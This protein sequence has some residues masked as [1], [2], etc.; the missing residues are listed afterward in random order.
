MSV[1]RAWIEEHLGAGTRDRPFSFTYGGS[2]S[3]DLLPGWRTTVDRE[4]LDAGRVRHLL[5][6]RDLRTGLV[7]RCEAIEY[8]AYD[9][10]E[11]ITYCRNEGDVDTPIIE[12]FKPI[13]MVVDSGGSDGFRVY[14]SRGSDSKVNDYE[15]LCEPVS[16]GSPLGLHSHGVKTC[17]EGPSGSPSVEYM[18]FFNVDAGGAGV[19]ATCGWSGPWMGEFI[20][21]DEGSLQMRIGMD[22]IHLALRP[23]EEIRGARNLVLFWEGDR[24]D[25][26]NQWRRLLLE[27]Y[28]PRPGGKPFAG[29]LTSAVWGAWMNCD[30]HIAEA[31]WWV[32]ND[33]P[34][35]CY[36]VDAGWGG[37]ID[38]SWVNQQ[39]D[40]VP[41]R[42][43][44]PDGMRPLADAVH[45]LGMKF[46]LW[47]VPESLDPEVEIGLEHPEWLG[48]PF[49]DPAYG[50]NVF[51]WLDHCDSEVNAFMIDYF[52]G[53]AREHGVDVF[54]QDGTPT[55]PVEEG[56]DREGINQ[57]RCVEGCYAFW[58]GLLEKDPK[59]MIDN[60]ATGG[61]RLDIET[62]KRSV[63]LWRSDCQANMDFDPI[64]SQTFT[65][66]LSHWIPLHG[67]VAPLVRMGAYAMRS[68][69]APAMM[70]GWPG[71]PADCKEGLDVDMLQR[72]MK[73][74]LSVRECFF[75]DFYPLTPCNLGQDQWMA[76]Q[77]DRPDK[78]IG[79][80]QAFRRSECAD[81]SVS[82]KIRGLDADACYT[83]IDV[84][85]DVDVDEPWQATGRVLMEEGVGITLT[86]RPDAALLV[87]RRQ[88]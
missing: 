80:V 64:T 71:K 34:L 9:A 88:G 47:L 46:L 15:L 6:W 74:Y 43:L 4:D 57:I 26:H 49:T 21:E 78:G 83:I 37:D 25:G 55:W 2:R 33:L 5:T 66:G 60:C 82:F 31:Q 85:V 50:D 45:E 39:S 84:D 87:Y 53:V 68:A 10:V 36:W 30:D 8:T 51:Y 54:R 28:S 3:A 27:Y 79:V 1:T 35:E 18:P 40:R 62:I 65:Y 77:F 7:V 22:R 48:E 58:D 59:L 73:E 24:I 11:W 13:D 63:A 52:S 41:N 12:D 61:R 72:F 38:K 76:W 44:F 29:L 19:I 67:A 70:V 86:T 75:G 69:Y 32:E 20:C 23:G 81:E 14:H 56:P 16:K 17:M 42:R